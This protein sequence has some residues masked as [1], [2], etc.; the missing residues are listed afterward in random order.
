MKEI[1][2]YVHASRIANVIEA[3]KSSSAWGHAG[4]DEHN[5]AV[6]V[7][8]GSLVPL[9]DAERHYSVELGEEIIN[10]YKVELHCHDDDVPT[11]IDAIRRSA[12]TGSTVAGWIYVVDIVSA[13]AI[14]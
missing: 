5:L 13:E 8:K 6:Y 7:V 3:L 9:D 12:R 1:K 4:H 10:E 2:A 14:R 11:L